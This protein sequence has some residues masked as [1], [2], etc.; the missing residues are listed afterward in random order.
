MH[1]EPNLVRRVLSG[2]TMGTRYCAVFFAPERRDLSRLHAA[3][4]QSVERVDRQMS[5]WRPDSDLMQVNA[6]PVGPW[7]DIPRE[8]TEV[9]AAALEIGKRSKGAFDAGVGDL[10][11]GWGFGPK[12]CEAAFASAAG[13]RKQVP[14]HLCVE[15]DEGRQRVRKHASVTLDLCGI[16][17]GY[18]VDEL[19]RVLEMDG[20]A[21]YLV[22]IDGEVRA[23]APKPDGSAWRVALERPEVGRRQA[24]GIVEIADAALATSGDY[25]RFVDNGGVRYGHTMDPHR[26]GPLLDGPAA[27][28][29][30]ASTCMAADGWATAMMVLGPERGHVLAATLD[31][32]VLFAVRDLPLNAAGGTTNRTSFPA[33][34][35]SG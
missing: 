7:L 1:I 17:K 10:V 19:A 20:I 18:G 4:Q 27:V 28:T 6:A 24:E 2:A 5:T 32:D 13:A 25:R 12:A 22:S 14:A 3:L 34:E 33:L 21:S 9:L 8:L 23:G 11:A 29:V 26:R 16:A 30:R 35:P 31:L 15:L